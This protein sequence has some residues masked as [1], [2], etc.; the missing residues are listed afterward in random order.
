MVIVRS[1]YVAL[2]STAALAA[3]CSSSGT[4]QSSDS[5]VPADSATGASPEGFCGRQCIADDHDRCIAFANRF[6][7]AFL[8]AYEVCGDDPKCI[9]PRLDAAAR[10]PRQL[11][12]AGDYCKAC[13]DGAAACVDAFFVHDHPGGTLAQLSDAR[14][15]VVDQT[16]MGK[17]TAE[18]GAA[19]L[20]KLT[21]NLDL[22]TCELPILEEDTKSTAICRKK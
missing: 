18:T 12:F 7:D 9:E 13:E 4:S 11:R 19:G 1:L 15:D 6:S 16:C 2:F 21:C 22:T 5:T 20:K 10:T 8:A 14:L 17:I 3:A